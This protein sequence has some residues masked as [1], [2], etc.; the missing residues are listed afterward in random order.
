MTLTSLMSLTATTPSKLKSGLSLVGGTMA[1]CQAPCARWWKILDPICLYCLNC[2]K[3]GQLILGKIIKI[4]ATRCHILRLKCTKFI[5]AGVLPQTPPRELTALSQTFYLDLRGPTSK[6]RKVRG[7]RWQETR[8]GRG[9]EGMGSGM[10]GP[11]DVG[12]AG[13]QVPGAQHCQKMGMK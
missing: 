13:R 4:V 7:G 1:L 12:S 11:A 5:S 8:E 10:W 2:T 9:G 6:G 3:F